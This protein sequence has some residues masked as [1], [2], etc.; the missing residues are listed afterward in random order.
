MGP[1]GAA[2]HFGLFGAFVGLLLG[3]TYSVGGFFID[4]ATIGLNQGTALAFGAIIGMPTIFFTIGAVAGVM[5]APLCRRIPMRY[6]GCADQ[7]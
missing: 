2:K 5:W 6:G 7:P 4:L 3:I 1:L